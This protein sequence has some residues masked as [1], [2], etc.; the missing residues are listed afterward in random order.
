MNIPDI[1]KNNISIKYFDII[2]PSKNIIIFKKK[3]NK[4]T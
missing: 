1:L 3:K 4:Y 2:I